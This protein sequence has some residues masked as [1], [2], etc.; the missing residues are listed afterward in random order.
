MIKGAVAPALCDELRADY[1]AYC[2]AQSGDEVVRDANGHRIRL[3]NLHLGSRAAQQIALNAKVLALLD[4]VFDA[5]AVVYSSLLFDVGTEQS[6]HRDA[7]YF[8]TDPPRRFLGVW[9]ALEDVMPDAG[10]LVYYEGGHLVSEEELALEAIRM[11]P[12]GSL[13]HE[14]LADARNRRY[15]ALVDERC[16]D[17]GCPRVTRTV[18]KGDTLIWHPLLPH[19]GAPI[20]N[21]SATRTSIV[22]HMVPRSAPVLPIYSYWGIEPRPPREEPKYVEC[23]GRQFFDHGYAH[24]QAPSDSRSRT[25]RV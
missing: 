12:D 13:A 11:H 20:E 4:L 6:L 3:A 19:G 9:T 15:L 2:E 7:P 23:M 21:P 24:F 18:Q 25:D 16:R 10:P 8:F 14:E 17:A 1:E 22:Y 5:E